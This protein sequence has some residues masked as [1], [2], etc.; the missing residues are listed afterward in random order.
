MPWKA[1][2][3]VA[4]QTMRVLSA[5]TEG[6]VMATPSRRNPNLYPE[7]L[8]RW[9]ASRGS[10][11]RGCTRSLLV[12][13]EPGGPGRRSTQRHGRAFGIRCGR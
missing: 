7:E 4:G 12:E 6:V 9:V 2:R 3:R 11:N 5:D 13:K 1:S 10:E 8:D